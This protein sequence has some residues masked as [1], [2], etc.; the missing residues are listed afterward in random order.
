MRAESGPCGDSLAG[1]AI[2]SV[3]RERVRLELG[4][5]GVFAKQHHG[6]FGSS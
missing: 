4:G 1:L 6:G 5:D 3:W 2:L